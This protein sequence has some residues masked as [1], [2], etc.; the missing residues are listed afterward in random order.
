MKSKGC[1]IVSLILFLSLLSIIVWDAFFFSAEKLSYQPIVKSFERAQKEEIAKTTLALLSGKNI[2]SPPPYM[3]EVGDKDYLVFVSF[4]LD[5]QRA[6]VGFGHEKTLLAAL[7][8]ACKNL[9]RLFSDAVPWGLGIL[10]VGLVEGISDVKQVDKD[11]RL[12]IL[13]GIEGL[14]FELKSSVFVMPEEVWGWNI[15]ED[16]GSIRLKIFERFLNRQSRG[17]SVAT[18]LQ[19]GKKVEVQSFRA[20]SFGLIRGSFYDF[21]RGKAIPLGEATSDSLE[22]SI[23]SAVA[24]LVRNQDSSGKFLYLLQP[25]NLSFSESYNVVRHAG[26]LWSLC[27]R[28]RAKP[29]EALLTAIV[30]A[31]NFLLSTIKEFEAPDGQK[32]YAPI[33]EKENE[34]KLGAAALGLLALVEYS[35]L[36]NDRSAE[37]VILELGKFVLFCQQPSGD[38]HNKYHV[39]RMQFLEFESDF[40]PGESILALIELYKHTNDARWLDAAKLGVKYLIEV[41]DANKPENALQPDQWLMIA[42]ERMYRIEPNPAWRDH[43]FRIAR[44]ILPRQNKTHRFMDYIGGFYEP[45]QSAVTG[46]RAEGLVAAYR[47]AVTGDPELAGQIKRSLFLVFDFLRFRQYTPELAMNVRRP[48]IIMG[49]FSESALSSSV[50]MDYI[51]HCISAVM[52][53]SEII[54]GQ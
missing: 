53:I 5:G 8:S 13:V 30:R 31:K 26:V 25:E 38:F 35:E 43:L 3:V 2:E 52:G 47:V 42:L 50:R 12:K 20:E 18:E 27:D 37:P 48:Q 32:L 23:S 16:G 41:R 51:Q 33:Y 39:R 22:S 10:K 7:E 29:S 45:P 49:A 54:G 40:Y 21:W 11:T 9:S 19:G 34:A 6:R 14:I 1:L 44:S 4:A 46:T 17:S 28:Y 36:I 15:L 24:Y